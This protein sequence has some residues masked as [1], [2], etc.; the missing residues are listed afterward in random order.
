ML[1]VAPRRF[2]YI[3]E[4]EDKKREA[5]EKQH[6]EPLIRQIRESV[7]GTDEAIDTPFGVRRMTYVDY[8]ASG[9]S[10]SFIEDYMRSE[11]MPMYANT[12]TVA[13]HS[14]KQ[15]TLFRTE[16][17]SIVKRG[18]NGGKD[19]VLIFAGSGSTSGINLLVGIL[20]IRA[21]AQSGAKPLVVIGPYEHHSNMLPWKE[22][23]AEVITIA[24]DAGGGIDLIDL[25][26]VLKQATNT[27][28]IGAFSAASNVTGILCPP[29]PVTLL[30]HKYDALSVWDYASAAAY[31]PMDMNPG[32][33]QASALD[34]IVFSPHKFV[35]G[36]GTPGVL[37]LKKKLIVDPIPV[38][39]G[40][41]T[42]FFVS[43]TTQRYLENFE[44]RLE[45]GTPDILGAIRCGLVFQLREAV[46]INE[47]AAR[48]Q[49]HCERALASFATNPRII[50]VGKAKDSHKRDRKSVV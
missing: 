29:E 39:P 25:E 38:N 26:R 5:L 7:I 12:H 10:L 13:S 37:V 18:V 14:G 1:I 3:H 9:R 46:G 6:H 49:R 4:D 45:G 34:A 43:D 15:T 47:I 48:E 40:G 2:A 35:G 41:G 27:L 22:A 21:H 19:D 11:V 28:K 20:Q 31:V 42:V 24:E 44:E 17:R 16:A 23:G 36:P 33:L 30:L 32:G 50:V 8:T